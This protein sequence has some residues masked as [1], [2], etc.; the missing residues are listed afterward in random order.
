M[1]TGLGSSRMSGCDDQRVKGERR[2]YRRSRHTKIKKR[3]KKK[4]RGELGWKEN[5]KKIKKNAGRGVLD[6]TNPF[7]VYDSLNIGSI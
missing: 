4:E 3:N 6:G 2:T 5:G 7:S 1:V